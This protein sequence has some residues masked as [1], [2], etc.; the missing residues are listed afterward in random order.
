MSI[1]KSGHKYEI[2][3]QT[4][5]KKSLTPAAI[6]DSKGN[7]IEGNKE[8][9]RRCGYTLSGVKGKSIAQLNLFSKSQLRQLEKL[10]TKALESQKAVAL[11]LNRGSGKE[12]QQL[13]L[14]VNPI[15]QKLSQDVLLLAITD[16]TD[17]RQLNQLKKRYT[18]L[19]DQIPVYVWVLGLLETGNTKIIE[20]NQAACDAY[21][22]TKYQMKGLDFSRIL[23]PHMPQSCA[24]LVRWLP[25]GKTVSLGLLTTARD[26]H[27]INIE[28]K[29][30][31]HISDNQKHIII[32]AVEVN[33]KHL[34]ESSYGFKDMLT[35]LYNRQYF[36]EELKRLNTSRQL[37]LTIIIADLNGLKLTNDAFGHKA[38]DRLLQ[39]AAEVLLTSCR[40]EDI[41]A[42]WGGDEFAILLPRFS[43]AAAERLMNR[44]QKA[45][46]NMESGEISL[47]ISIG[48]ATKSIPKESIAA[49][50]KK[51][52][53]NM[54][55][56]KVMERKSVYGGI[57]D[58][59]LDKLRQKSRQSVQH[60][61]FLENL[62]AEFG[63]SM[64]LPEHKVKDLKMLAGIYDIGKITVPVSILNK[65]D[66]LSSSEWEVIKKHPETGYRISEPTPQL[67]NL[68]DAILSHHEWWDG[69]G[70][71]QRLK[72]EEIPLM[73][74]A[75]AII[76]AYDAMVKGRPYRK[77]LS[78]KQALGQ[79]R[80][81][82][83]IQ[84]DPNLVEKF[85]NIISSN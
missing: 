11:T 43:P 24:D 13:Y 64:D 17:R 84:F 76:D 4:L 49:T 41:I 75:I 22:Y 30:R 33:H 6:I 27:L 51:A 55:A 29:C 3:Y 45:C 18:A 12:N 85:I 53:S 40:K 79:L 83:G 81:Y 60:I 52:E 66:K 67:L 61:R 68:A 1:L 44:I 37:P 57:L 14:K 71:P 31:L 63:R 54:Y 32:T 48:A 47:S 2:D 46:K 15:I 69:S 16:I 58:S 38:G 10:I 42:R 7:I 9:A 26:G 78:H 36:E 5:F 70:Y 8:F 20:A 62:A 56:Q 80:K 50:L 19:L 74:R 35:G 72:G 34:E 77:A 65:R 21:G 23:F 25:R 59:L 82:S 73:A 28:A 39:Q